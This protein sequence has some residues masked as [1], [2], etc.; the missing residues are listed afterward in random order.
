MRFGALIA[1]Y[2]DRHR[3]PPGIPGWSQVNGFRGKTDTLAKMQRRVDHDLAYVEPPA[4]LAEPGRSRRADPDR[5]RDRHHQRQ[6]QQRSAQDEVLG[7]L[8]ARPPLAFGGQQRT[9]LAGRPR[10]R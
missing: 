10:G 5:D 6:N 1:G 9:V 4:R 7:A 2:A 8:G 3:L